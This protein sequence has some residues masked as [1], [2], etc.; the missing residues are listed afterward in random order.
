MAEAKTP[1]RKL[2]SLVP[3]LDSDEG[4]RYR[5]IVIR[6][7]LSGGQVTQEMEIADRLSAIGSSL[8]KSGVQEIPEYWSDSLD[9]RSGQRQTKH[10]RS[11]Q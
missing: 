8:R 9:R 10:R 3:D 6:G 2:A 1:K 4:Q 5:R 11:T 7:C